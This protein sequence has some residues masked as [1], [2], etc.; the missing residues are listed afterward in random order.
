MQSKPEFFFSYNLCF[1]SRL[2]LSFDYL[3]LSLDSVYLSLEYIFDHFFES[4]DAYIFI[5][6][7]FLESTEAFLLR[8][9]SY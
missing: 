9:N 7:D 8:V 2:C 5:T 4:A 1:N 3:I 6:V